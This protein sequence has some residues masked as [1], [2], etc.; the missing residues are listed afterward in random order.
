MLFEFNLWSGLLLPTVVNGFL[1]AYLIWQRGRTEERISDYLLTGLLLV[2]TLRV[3]QW[4]LGFAHWY[5]SHD[6][7]STF[8]FYFPFNHW[9]SIGPLTYF[10]FQSLTNHHFRIQGKAWLHF[11]PEGILLA[12]YLVIFFA[13]VVIFHLI[14]GQ[15]FPAHYGTQGPWAQ[16]I[17]PILDH[18][19]F[20]YLYA[21]LPVYFFLTFRQYRS[22]QRYLRNNFSHTDHLRFV[23]L[24]NVMLAVV[25]AIF[26]GL[27]FNLTEWIS[28]VELSYKQNWFAY[29][30]WGMLVVYL[31]IQGYSAQVQ[32][33]P[34]L[35]FAPDE[36]EPE[37]EVL[38][39]SPEKTDPQWA[40]L[41]NRLEQL[42]AE[43]KP[44][45]DPELTLAQLAARLDTQPALLSRYINQDLGRN[46]N[47]YING[48]R[49]EA[50]KAALRDPGNS[51]LSLLGIALDHG[52][53][54]KATFNRVFKKL[55]GLSPS[56]FLK[57]GG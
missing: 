6:G 1:F 51:H 13:D 46:F 38:L 20:I 22:Y 53:N 47:D 36:P 3:T 32:P 12:G 48:F 50:V 49:V 29:L 40:N 56:E 33:Q 4:M 21:S 7:Y 19:L 26:I 44:W 28:G 43:Q 45:L 14:R 39:S 57:S 52:F 10:L 11:L 31:G 16:H 24:R 37:P 30:G 23:W 42:M 34:A 25:A 5:D 15:A 35:A 17:T 41:R 54:S 18:V 2:F 55:E 8:M 9:V 27:L